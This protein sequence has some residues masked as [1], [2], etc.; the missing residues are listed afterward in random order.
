MVLKRQNIISIMFSLYEV[1]CVV[2]EHLSTYTLLSYPTWKVQ[3]KN[4]MVTKK[5]F[6]RRESYE[7]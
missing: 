5:L 2:C 6:Y 4:I 1:L 7:V 3:G